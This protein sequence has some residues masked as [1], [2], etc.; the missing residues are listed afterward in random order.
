MEALCIVQQRAIER[1]KTPYNFRVYHERLELVVGGR[2]KI[3]T[4]GWLSS[5]QFEEAILPYDLTTL[6]L[7]V[8]S[9]IQWVF[10]SKQIAFT[11]RSPADGR[12]AFEM[13]RA[14]VPVL[15]QDLVDLVSKHAN[16]YVSE[17]KAFQ[18]SINEELVYNDCDTWFLW[19]M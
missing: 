2:F 7:T 12:E 13:P 9:E 6:T 4:C 18:S 14:N 8:G 10:H 11:P 3:K 19:L 17:T 5:V 1:L 15:L 16:D